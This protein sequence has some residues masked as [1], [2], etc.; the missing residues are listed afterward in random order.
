MLLLETFSRYFWRL[1]FLDVVDTGDDLGGFHV[2]WVW[3]SSCL[4][5]KM[6]IVLVYCHIIL[7]F[8]SDEYLVLTRLVF[9]FARLLVVLRCV[10]G[11]RL[12]APVWSKWYLL[13]GVAFAVFR[14]LR[15]T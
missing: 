8:Y 3:M 9:C 11:W 15:C 10:L 6:W 5:M 13:S 12:V 14:F 4:Y 1:C 2:L 7:L